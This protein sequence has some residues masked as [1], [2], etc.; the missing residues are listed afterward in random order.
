MPNLRGTRRVPFLKPPITVPT[1]SVLWLDANDLTT[2]FTSN[3]GTGAVTADGDVVGFWGDK[4]GAAFDMTSA[5]DDTTRP[6]FKIVNGRRL[7]RF[8]GSNDILRRTANLGLYGAG[9]CTMGFSLKSSSVPNKYLYAN[10]N[11]ASANAVYGIWTSG[12]T[13]L[14]PFIRNDANTLIGNNAENDTGP[15]VDGVSHSLIVTDT[16]SLFSFYVDGVF[17]G[18]QAYTRSGALTLTRTSIGGR[19][20][21]TT[22][23][24]TALDLAA[25]VA[26]TSVLNPTKIDELNAYLTSVKP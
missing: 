26:Y 19:V 25:F 14:S 10:G 11:F 8:D 24:W 6:A 18:S 5:A 17:G 20:R 2:L 13:G 4:S 21:N 15:V 22:D 7:I 16:G 23:A 9:A 3:A 12:S 1:G